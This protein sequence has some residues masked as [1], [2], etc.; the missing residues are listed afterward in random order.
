MEMPHDNHKGSYSFLQLK[1][2]LLIYGDRGTT[3]RSAEKCGKNQDGHERLKRIIERC[4]TA[5]RFPAIF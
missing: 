3:L 4:H 2:L 1:S 5:S